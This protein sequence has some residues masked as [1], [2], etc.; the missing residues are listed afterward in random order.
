M[1]AS[2]LI[3]KAVEFSNRQEGLMVSSVI[4]DRWWRLKTAVFKPRLVGTFIEIKDNIM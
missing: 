4:C 3:I 2:S 1:S